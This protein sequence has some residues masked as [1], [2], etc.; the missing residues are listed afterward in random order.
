M[1]AKHS[2]KPVR[3]KTVKQADSLQSTG[4]A[5]GSRSRIWRQ[6]LE[7]LAA[8]K[9]TYGHCCVSTLDKRH[10]S[11]GNWVRTQ[12]GR[13]RRG[14]LSQEQIRVLDQLGFSWEGK[15]ELERRRQVK[16]EA[17]YEALAAYQR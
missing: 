17:K 14:Q 2:T 11:L 13:R 10:V 12:R 15:S 6:R 8:F 4:S 9:K 16:W 5:S 1:P 3:S 7:E